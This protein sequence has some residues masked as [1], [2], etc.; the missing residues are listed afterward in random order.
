MPSD[1]EAETF[2]ELCDALAG[3]ATPQAENEVGSTFDSRLRAC[4]TLAEAGEGVLGL[5]TLA[6]N[7]YEYEVSLT[8]EQAEVIERLATAWGVPG[9]QWS[10]IRELLK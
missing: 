9:E 7:L 4:R 2:N 10:F 5:E 6:S 1:I 3:R 8:A